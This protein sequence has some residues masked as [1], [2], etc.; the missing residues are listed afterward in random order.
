MQPADMAAL[1]RAQFEQLAAGMALAR[2]QYDGIRRNALLALGAARAKAAL[3]VVERLTRDENPV[4][5]EA[6]AWALAQIS[7]RRGNQDL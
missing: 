4:I 6:A 2:A 5:R 3:P 1:S 7:E